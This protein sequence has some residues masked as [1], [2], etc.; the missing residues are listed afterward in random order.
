MSMELTFF[1]HDICRFSDNTKL[2]IVRLCFCRRYVNI[3]VNK[4]CPLIKLLI[5]TKGNKRITEKKMQRLA[6][7][8]SAGPYFSYRNSTVMWLS[9]LIVLDLPIN[10]A[11]QRNYAGNK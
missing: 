8:D 1:N 2:V 7:R 3:V 6:P 4:K 5:K 11:Y 9:T 10:S